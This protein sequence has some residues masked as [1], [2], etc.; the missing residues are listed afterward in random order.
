MIYTIVPSKT[1]KRQYKKLCKSDP[2][3]LADLQKIVDILAVNAVLPM[4]NRNH[5]LAGNLE[6][7]WECHVAPDWLLIYR[8][9]HDALI[10]ELIATGSHSELF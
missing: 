7:C 10:L 4:R 6:D 1:Y 3:L 9:Y 5:K 2:K 8:Y